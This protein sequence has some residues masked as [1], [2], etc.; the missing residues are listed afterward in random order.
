MKPIR[1]FFSSWKVLIAG[2]IALSLYLL[3]P[4][5]LVRADPTAGTFDLGYLQWLGLAAAATFLSGFIGWACFQLFFAS[6]D[7]E[8]STDGDEWG[9]LKYD[10]SK[11][12]HAQRYLAV[13]GAFAFCILLFC[14]WAFVIPK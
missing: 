8:T 9:G 7:K 6:M 3:L 4:V 2:A 13:Q 5:V 12:T 1:R 14:F 11:L 10:F